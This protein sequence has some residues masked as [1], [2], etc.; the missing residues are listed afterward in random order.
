MSGDYGLNDSLEYLEFEFDSFDSDRGINSNVSPLNWPLFLLGRPLTDIA[1]IKILEVQIPFSYYVINS[2]NNTFIVQYAVG[3]SITTQQFTV[4][5][6]V[7]NY[8]AASFRTAANTAIDAATG[9]SWTLTY[10]NITNKISYSAPQPALQAFVIDNSN[11]TFDLS[12]SDSPQPVTIP[13]GTYTGATL[14]A[15]IELAIQAVIV[16]T[17]TV[18][19]TANLFVFTWVN[20][21][22]F[23]EGPV[24]SF[25]NSLQQLLGF[26]SS[27]NIFSKSGTTYTLSSVNQL[28]PN[29][30]FIFG[31][32]ADE[33]I[34]NPRLAMGFGPGATYGDISGGTVTIISNSIQITGPNYIYINSSLLGS[35][36]KLYLPQG[37]DSTRGTLSFQMAKVPVNCNPNGVIY[38]IDPDPQKWYFKKLTKGLIWKI[39]QI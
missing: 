16:P 18:T 2:T 30:A 39:W 27:S 17:W 24:L 31:T 33:G 8:T 19:F 13:N 6:P 20:A 15:A 36:C 11:N 35:S 22:T 9:A 21:S 25:T 10:S 14:A 34:L 29:Y 3:D 1:S 26:T 7:G 28:I 38:W 32:S 23:I 5:I 4:T 37:N 12:S